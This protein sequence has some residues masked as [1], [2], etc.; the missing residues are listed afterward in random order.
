MLVQFIVLLLLLSVCL[1][2]KQNVNYVL[3][4]QK[5]FY[6]STFKIGTPPKTF[7][8]M[9]DVTCTTFLLYTGAK[10]K[11]RLRLMESDENVQAY[12]PKSSQS[13]QRIGVYTEN[14]NMSNESF[15]STSV[16]NMESP[17]SVVLVRDLV[18]HGNRSLGKLKFGL[19]DYDSQLHKLI[20]FDGL[21]GLDRLLL[22]E[23]TDW[24]QNEMKTAGSQTITFYPILKRGAKPENS[25]AILS[26]GDQKPDQCENQ[27]VHF[28]MFVF[29][30]SHSFFDF[31][32]TSAMYGDFN[33]MYP[34][35]HD[36]L[37]SVST[38]TTFITVDE[39]MY[40]IIVKTLKPTREDG[41]FFSRD[42]VD[43]NH[44]ITAPPLIFSGPHNYNFTI[45]PSFYIHFS[46]STGKCNL[47]IRKNSAE[48]KKRWVLGQPF[49][50]TH[51]VSWFF[52][53]SSVAFARSIAK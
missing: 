52:G 24:P 44:L 22:Q 29:N 35:V 47:K 5:H 45:P 10:K 39:V 27:W 46:E 28:P 31:Q 12:D 6:E 16:S 33:I 1:S 20:S 37:F 43:C 15:Y 25:D 34:N 53:N 8:L 13:Y 51:C 38:L 42:I 21:F 48:F 18:Y 50:L 17:V 9:F 11:T 32:L 36:T 3:T 30:S 26:F 41:G 49:F 2:A 23:V 19:I 14:I 40:S 7:R 4:H